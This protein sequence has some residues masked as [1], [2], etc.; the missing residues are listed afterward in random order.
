MEGYTNIGFM[1]GMEVPAVQRYGFGYVIGANDAAKVKY[2]ENSAYTLKIS[3]GYTGGF[4]ANDNVFTNAD[5]W[6]SS[7]VETI[8]ACG[9]KLYQ[10]VVQALG[11]HADAT[12]IGVDTDQALDHERIITSAMKELHRSVYET[13][14]GL[15]EQVT[16]E[17][18]VGD[19]DWQDNI[20]GTTRVLGA[21]EG[22]VGLA[23][24]SSWR[25]ENYTVEEYETL[26]NS[27]KN[28]EIKTLPTIEE[29]NNYLKADKNWKPTVESYV[30][31]DYNA[32]K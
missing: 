27:I 19:V 6:Y 13:L 30:T 1:G 18:T 22:M 10:S 20:G 14:E 5:N 15:Y 9:G 24:G 2:A 26:F 28:G 7:G 4:I 23:T 3:Y 17:T 31:V 11:S 25:L 32:Y 8:F 12:M 21:S 29:F 16:E